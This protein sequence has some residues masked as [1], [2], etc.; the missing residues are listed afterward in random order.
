M[1]RTWLM[2]VCFF[3]FSI[4]F[5]MADVSNPNV[6]LIMYARQG[7]LAGVESAL[8]QL[9]KLPAPMAA[10][11]AF[12]RRLAAGEFPAVPGDLPPEIQKF[13]TQLLDAIKEA[14]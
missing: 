3:V 14:N 13:L 5:I 10:L 4:N 12:L 9:D 8:A 2:A 6:Q 11:A 7:N 1:N